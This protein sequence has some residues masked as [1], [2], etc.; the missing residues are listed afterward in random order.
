MSDRPSNGRLVDRL[1]STKLAQVLSYRDFRLLWIGAFV[2]FTGSWISNVA[3]G[4]YVYSV[5]HDESK[6]GLINFA[7]SIPVCLFGLFAGSATDMFNK[8]V[9]LVICQFL[10]G[11]TTLFMAF[12]IWMHFIEYW[13]IVLVALLNGLISCIE[14]PTRQSI[15]SNVVPSEVLS[16]AVPVNAMTFNVARVLGPAIGAVL[17]AS[18][19]TASC[20]FVDG[21]SYLA[22]IWAVVG[23]KASLKS[24]PKPPQPLRDLIMEGA[25]Y[26][27]R[28]RRL[29]TLFLLENL[30][31][32]F[33]LAFL[34]LLPAFVQDVMHQG[35]VIRDGHRVDLL[36]Q[37]TGFAFTAVGVGSLCALLFITSIADKDRKALIIRVAMLT[38]GFGLPILSFCTN[39]WLAYPILAMMGAATVTQLNTTNTLFQ[40][41]APERL[42]GRVLAM[43]IWAVN[44]IAPFGTLFFSWLATF[45]RTHPEFMFFSH[46]VRFPDVGMPLVLRLTGSVMLIGGLVACLSRKG[47]NRLSGRPMQRV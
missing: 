44:G 7:W 14:M 31:S 10:L 13:M 38:L 45:S 8:R 22:I 35:I 40:G 26:T 18:I 12:A 47:L 6:L 30:T 5:T 20:F 42:R 23:I 28:D 39:P 36:K 29:R 11:C 33:G 16:A 41:L 4:Y 24:S 43:H 15:V 1:L 32:C 46:A 19:G 2:S 3:R 25:L 37:G 21:I 17:L 9:V 27:W 34:P